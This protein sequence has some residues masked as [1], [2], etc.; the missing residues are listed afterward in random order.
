MGGYGAD[1]CVGELNGYDFVSDRLLPDLHQIFGLPRPADDPFIP[2]AI[3][4]E[5]FVIP[6]GWSMDG[7]RLWLTVT[8]LKWLGNDLFRYEMGPRQAGVIE[9][10]T[11]G[12]RF[13]TLAANPDSDYAFNGS[14]EPALISQPYHPK[15]CP[16]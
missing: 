3:G 2:R 1:N 13:I 10:S 14:P 9:L 8:P 16:Q 7:M 6:H 12:P 15:V 5:L 4:D 11:A